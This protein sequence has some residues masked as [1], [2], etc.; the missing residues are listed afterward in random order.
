MGQAQQV[1]GAAISA[2]RLGELLGDMT[3]GR[4]AYRNLAA[5]VRAL[6]LDGRIAVDARLPAE[7]ELAPALALSRTTISA[8]YELLRKS[9][10]ARSRRGSGTWTALPEEALPA[11]ESEPGAG[12]PRPPDGETLLPPPESVVDLATAALSMPQDVLNRDLAEAA[13]RLPHRA[14]TPGYHS[15]GLPELRAAVAARYTARGLPTDPEQILVTSGAQQA[16][17]LT[18]SLLCGP[19]DRVLA[20]SPSYPNALDAIRR[21][22]LRLVP[23]PVTEDGWDGEVLASALRQ[24]VPRLAYLIPA[25]HNPTGS[26]MPPEQCAE[27]LGATR[28][29]GTWL[30]VDETLADVALDTGPPPPFVAYGADGR[31]DHVISIGS[32][33]KCYWGGLRVGWLRASPRL[34]AE[35]AELRATVDVSG[36][37]LDQL[38]ALSLLERGDGWLADRVDQVRHRRQVL[39]AALERHLPHWSWQLPPG[40][41]SLWVDLG[42]PIAS[43]LAE[44]ALAQGVRIG[45]GARFGDEPGLYEHRL[46]IPYTLPPAVL[47]EAVRRL[48]AILADDPAPVSGAAPS[49]GDW[50][51]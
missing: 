17:S 40:G 22:R 37:V 8:A 3:S 32:L 45:S 28:R 33:S 16:L 48:A 2:G 50:V 51:A 4:P 44:R 47:G 46:R 15:Y 6:V 5:A 20:E 23:V 41:L 49:P 13:L 24:T 10:Y 19:G 12:S 43:A 42:R 26:L 30:V 21:A 39:V 36:S 29:P 38:L 14:R 27:V 34:V 31:A 7:R 25:F 9:G 11:A 35:L 1:R 18:L